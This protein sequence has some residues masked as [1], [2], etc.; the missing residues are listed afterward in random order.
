MCGNR[1]ILPIAETT[2]LARPVNRPTM[3][4][5]RDFNWFIT[6]V[7]QLLAM[8]PKWEAI[9]PSRPGRPLKNDA[10]SLTLPR[11]YEAMWLTPF[12]M[13]CQALVAA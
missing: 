10:M 1:S 5:G 2:R 6:A 9:P 3:S 12:W 13:L 4:P 8:V 11:M 7:A